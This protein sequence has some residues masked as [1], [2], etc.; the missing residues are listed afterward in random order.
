MKAI[1]EAIRLCDGANETQASS[2]ANKMKQFYPK[3]T[4]EKLMAMKWNDFRTIQSNFLGFIKNQNLGR[5]DLAHSDI[6]DL[7][8]CL[9][10]LGLK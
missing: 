7:E 8:R 9:E 2:L 6:L 1:D 3:V 5:Y 4:K 10:R